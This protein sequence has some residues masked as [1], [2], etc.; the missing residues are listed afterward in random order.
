MRGLEARSAF[1]QPGEL[2]TLDVLARTSAI[3]ALGRLGRRTEKK[4]ILGYA[5]SSRPAWAEEGPEIS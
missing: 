4:V 1:C 2:S 3:S 5:V